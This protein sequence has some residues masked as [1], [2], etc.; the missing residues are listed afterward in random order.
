MILKIYNY[1]HKILCPNFKKTKMLLEASSR[2]NAWSM[3]YNF[4]RE[5][6]GSIRRNLI[7]LKKIIPIEMLK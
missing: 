6:F 4:F 2:S 3:S 1:T 7:H 5:I